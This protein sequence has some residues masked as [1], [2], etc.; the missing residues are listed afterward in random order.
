VCRRRRRRKSH[1]QYA[2]ESHFVLQLRAV[3]L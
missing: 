1:T 2:H 3:G